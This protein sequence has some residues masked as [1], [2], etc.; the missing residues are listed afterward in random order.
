[1]K[2]L[3]T[4]AAV[5][6]LA[7]GSDPAFAAGTAYTFDA[8]VAP[9]CSLSASSASFGTITD[10]NATGAVAIAND[11]SYC[12]AAGT[13]VTV[14]H[15]LLHT[16]SATP[17]PTGFTND[18]EFVP[19]VT[20]NE[21]ETVVGDQ[22]TPVNLRAFTGVHVKATLNAPSGHLVAGT[23]NGSITLTLTVIS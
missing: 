21:G 1:M 22:S 7:L 18:I 19:T 5:G 12:N 11:S 15:N 16:A 13:K 20:T 14:S 3:M 10:A 4:V 17:V 2:K 8:T 9:V 6:A 23:Y